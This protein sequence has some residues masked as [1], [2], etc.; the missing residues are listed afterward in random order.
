MMA[1]DDGNRLWKDGREANIPEHHGPCSHN[2][3]AYFW[4]SQ[5]Q[6]G[7]EDYAA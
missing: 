4:L 5:A 7:P 2:L 1:P 6:G 3:I